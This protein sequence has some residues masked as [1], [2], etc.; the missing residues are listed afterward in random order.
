VSFRDD[1]EWVDARDRWIDPQEDDP[2]VAAIARRLAAERM[3][4][5]ENDWY[6][7]RR[8]Q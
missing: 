1:P 2:A 5:I 4:Q 3:R 8:P 6:T 7:A